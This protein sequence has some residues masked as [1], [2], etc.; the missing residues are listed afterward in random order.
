MRLGSKVASY[1]LNQIGVTDASKK[2]SEEG[3]VSV[4]KMRPVFEKML[5]P[6]DDDKED[7]DKDENEGEADQGLF[8]K[9]DKARQKV[10][11]VF[12][13]LSLLGL[14]VTATY[15]EFDG[16]ETHKI[17]VGLYTLYVWDF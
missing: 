13:Q 2:I 12:L 16:D 4:N 9:L 11:Y 6:S 5:A 14:W 15:S 7:K 10:V 3:S 8:E 1:S 17:L